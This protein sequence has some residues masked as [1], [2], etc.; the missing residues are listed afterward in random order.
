M[1][2]Y[3]IARVGEFV[4]GQP[5]LLDNGNQA[6]LSCSDRY[7]QKA[8]HM[9]VV[10]VIPGLEDLSA[11]K[12]IADLCRQELGFVRRAILEQAIGEGRILVAKKA[13]EVLGFVHF[14]VT[15]QGCATIYEIAVA[16]PFRRCGV[17][18]YLLDAVA[19]RAREAGVSRLRLKCPIDL[20]ANGFYAR[21][22]FARVA[23]EPGRR[24][25]L[26]VWEKLLPPPPSS[27]Q[28]VLS[29]TNHTQAIRTLIASWE[30]G[31]DSRNPFANLIITP[32]FASDSAL[33][34][35]RDLKERGAQVFFDSGGYQVQMGRIRYEELFRRLLE[36][37]R[38][39]D[40]ADWY[41]LPDFVPSSAD[42]EEE[43]EI[44]VRDTLDY[45]RLFLSR[46]PSDFIERA[47]GVVHGRTE[48]QVRRCVE[49]YARIGVRYLGF[50]SFGTS[51]PRGSVNVISRNSVRLLQVLQTLAD[52]LHLRI[53]VFGI[54]GPS[55]LAR[56]VG[57]GIRPASFDSAGWWKAGAYG[58][59]FFPGRSQIHLTA[60]PAS[61]DTWAQIEQEKNRTGHRCPFCRDVPLL[62]VSRQHRILHNLAV[63][64]DIV[65]NLNAR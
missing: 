45:A 47:I 57:A 11:I 7:F 35:V 26:V 19:G 6:I 29:L 25:H 54:G 27:P 65:N 48:E 58:N 32:L 8:S 39:Y 46:M 2:A 5:K 41:V 40:W 12:A 43:V 61:P 55:S 49:A 16:P 44:K 37:Y 38:A 42:S 36:V 50:G 23:V 56:L 13:G 1:S 33:A 64:L 17:G 59:I 24:R 60:L 21:M 52:D 14:A 10:V 20:P 3:R 28:F 31:A 63:I 51:G 18:R 62:Y 34:I 9:G 15:R 53:H 4:N 30:S 22:G